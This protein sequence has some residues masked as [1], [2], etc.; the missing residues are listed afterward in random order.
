MPAFFSFEG[1]GDFKK[2]KKKV[3]R[4]AREVNKMNYDEWQLDLEIWWSKGHFQPLEKYI[5]MEGKA[6]YEK[7][8]EKEGE[9]I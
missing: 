5:P 8:V 3:Q 2:K 1:C 6:N 9:K 7:F 4:K